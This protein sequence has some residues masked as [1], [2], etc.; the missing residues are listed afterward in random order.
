MP[1]KIVTFFLALI[2][3]L[4]PFE[5]KYDKLFR[6]SSLKLVP[7]GLEF[8]SSYDKKIYFYL[9]DIFALL[10]F[11]ATLFLIQNRRKLFQ[12]PLWIIFLSAFFSI[13]LSPFAHY[14]L[15]YFRL[16]QLLTPVLLF[17]TIQTIFRPQDSLFKWI[18]S[19][20]V[21]AG[22]CQSIIGILQYSQQDALGLRLIG[23]V[24]PHAHFTSHHGQ[25][26]LID[27]LLGKHYA[28]DVVM[29][30]SG[31]FPNV[32]VFGGFLFLSILMTYGLIFSMEKRWKLLCLTLPLQFLALLTSY[33]RSALFALGLASSIWILCIFLNADPKKSRLRFFVPFILISFPLTFCLR[34]GSIRSI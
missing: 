30:A 20:I 23:E 26:W 1:K 12:N 22:I 18:A 21:L 24:S 32:N 13:I 3:V 11:V 9:S 14:P 25:R 16:L 33:S 2:A 5:H 27:S 8:A 19:A 10:L 7:Q 28:S 31:T 34:L 4:I 17:S 29:R 6:F 15:P